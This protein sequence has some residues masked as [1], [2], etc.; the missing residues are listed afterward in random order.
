MR[1]IGG[2]ISDTK[3]SIMARIINTVYVQILRSLEKCPRYCYQGYNCN[4]VN[5][6]N[7]P[8]PVVSVSRGHLIRPQ[9]ICRYIP[10]SEY[11][12]VVRLSKNFKQFSSAVTWILIDI[13]VVII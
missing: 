12:L 11:G 6:P 10:R 13:S 1:S 2:N 5:H 7:V 8:S 3:S 4:K 9:R